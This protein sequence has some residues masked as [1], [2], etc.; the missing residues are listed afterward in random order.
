MNDLPPAPRSRKSSEERAEL[1]RL[2]IK[3]KREA[4]LRVTSGEGKRGRPQE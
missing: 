4:E 3:R 1:R 2:A